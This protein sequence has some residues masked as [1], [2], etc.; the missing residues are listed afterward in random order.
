MRNLLFA[1]L[2]LFVLT[3][4]FMVIGDCCREC[5]YRDMAYASCCGPKE[6]GI[7]DS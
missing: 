6:V 3:V 7:G 5:P 4:G 1:F 2:A